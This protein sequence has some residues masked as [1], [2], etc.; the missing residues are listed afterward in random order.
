MI[1]VPDNFLRHGILFPGILLLAEGLT[2]LATKPLDNATLHSLIG[3]FTDRL[4]S[5]KLFSAALYM[6][7]LN[8]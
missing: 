6:K 7:D 3:F 8:L 1:L 5:R 4:V 2:C